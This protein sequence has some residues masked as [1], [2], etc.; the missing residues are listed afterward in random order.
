MH[1][2]LEMVRNEIEA[3][4]GQEQYLASALFLKV[5]REVP[6]EDD[7]DN[8]L[9]DKAGFEELQNRVTN[10]LRGKTEFDPKEELLSWQIGVLRQ[11]ARDFFNIWVDYKDERFGASDIFSDGENCMALEA[12]LEKIN[13][14]P[15]ENFSAILEIEQTLTKLATSPTQFVTE[16]DKYWSFKGAITSKGDSLN[17]FTQK[18]I[19]LEKSATMIAGVVRGMKD[20][21]DRCQ[22]NA[23]QLP[24]AHHLLWINAHILVES[25][26]NAIES[27]LEFEYLDNIELSLHHWLDSLFPQRMIANLPNPLHQS[28][29]HHGIIAN[30]TQATQCM[31]QYVSH[32]NDAFEQRDEIIVPHFIEALE[33]VKRI[34]LKNISALKQEGMQT[35]AFS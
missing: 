5:Y 24:G 34:S 12:S 7:G 23:R 3:A 26:T 17:A 14:D 35:K 11:M 25:F 10:V 9:Q 18:R 1:Q 4:A 33:R 29:T 21:S 32:G 30:L 19:D 28:P 20:V 8:Q 31:V 13:E 15:T 27:F 2:Y 6:Y 16:L 22:R